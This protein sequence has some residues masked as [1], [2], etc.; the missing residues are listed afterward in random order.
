MVTRTVRALTLLAALAAS[1]ALGPPAA[2][3]PQEPA[4]RRAVQ[5]RCDWT[6]CTLRLDRNWTHRATDA[7]WVTGTLAGL[8]A[9]LGSPLAATACAVYV[10]G[11]A[12][13]IAAEAREYHKAGDCLGLRHPHLSP[14]PVVEPIRVA[15]G[16]HNCT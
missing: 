13:T 8:C 9:L 14:L 10:G 16:T 7:A 12:A 6:A 15:A 2:A 4:T 3:E 5:A 1:L 11:H